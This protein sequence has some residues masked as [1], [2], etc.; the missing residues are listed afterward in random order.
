MHVMSPVA[1]ALLLQRLTVTACVPTLRWPFSNPMVPPGWISPP[2]LPDLSCR[3]FLDVGASATLR[4]RSKYRTH[5][6]HLHPGH[7]F[8]PAS[9]DNLRA[10][11]QAYHGVPSYPEQH[12]FGPLS[13]RHQRAVSCECPPRT[14]H[15][16]CTDSGL[17]VPFLRTVAR[18]R[19][20]QVLLGADSLL[21]K[22]SVFGCRSRFGALELP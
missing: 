20:R 15:G 19:W 5:A 8:V 10:A 11:W 9:I 14:E 1:V 2:T 21:I 12:H 4:E 6:G 17:C 3:C 18:Q 22:S 13:R 7:I 16:S